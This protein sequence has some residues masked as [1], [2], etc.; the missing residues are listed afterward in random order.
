MA[1]NAETSVVQAVQTVDIALLTMYNWSLFA[2][3]IALYY[4]A[5]V[6]KA[7]SRLIP[8]FAFGIATVNYYIYCLWSAC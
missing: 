7:S 1:L 6:L 4:S 2:G 8:L 5:A 3:A